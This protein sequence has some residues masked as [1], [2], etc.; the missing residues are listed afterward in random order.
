VKLS[1]RPRGGFA[2]RG[3][4]LPGADY[5]LRGPT[6]F[7]GERWGRAVTVRIGNHEDPGASEVA[8]AEPGCHEFEA[9]SKLVAVRSGPEGIV[10]SRQRGKPSDW[11]SDLWLAERLAVG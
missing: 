5:R 1:E 7:A 3:P 8:V 10:V 2:L 4:A 11:L 6:V 9:S